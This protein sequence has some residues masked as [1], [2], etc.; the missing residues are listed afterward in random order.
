MKRAASLAGKDL[1][2]A[3]AE[4]KGFPGVSGNIT[5]DAQRNARKPAVMLRMEG[6]KPHYVATIYPEEK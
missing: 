5:M 4:T 6:G 3:I 2:K 1:A